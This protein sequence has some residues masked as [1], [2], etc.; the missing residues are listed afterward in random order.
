MADKTLFG[1]LQ[2]LFS[3][4][5]IVRKTEKGVKIV[6]TDEY[7]NMTTNLVDRYMKLKVSNYGVGG[8]ESAMA[9]QQVRIDLFR[10]YDSMDMDP[11][12][13]SALD[14][15]ADEC[16]AKNEHGSILKIHHDDDNIKQ[17]LENLFYDILNIE[18]NLW[19]WTRNLVKY[20]DFFLEL[21]I[22]DELGIINVMPLSS[23]EMSRVEGFDPENPQR[24]KFVY[25]PYQNPYM[26]VGQTT[27]KEFENYEIA[28]FRLNSDSNF[29]PYGKSMVEGARRVWKQLMLMEDAMLIHRVM[30]APEKRIFKVDVGNIPPNEVDNYMQ[31]IINASKK[32]PFVD[33]RTGEYNLKYNMM[34]LIE[35]YYMPVRG[36][37]N[38]TSIDT[39]KG[40]EYNM[41][42]DINYLKGKL[43]AALKIPKA[44][45]GYEE[46]TNGKATLA[47]MDI[48][49]AKTIERVQRVLISELTKIA[50][51]HLYAQG[52]N[53]DRLTDFTLELTVP[54]R[55]YEQEQVELYTSK[56]A[57]IQQMQQTKMFS[58]EWMYESVM[59][60]AKD[61]QDE[62]TLQ[63]LDDT[64][65]MFRL[66]SI[67]TQGV[68]PAKETGTEGGPTN[69]EEE[70]NK[71]KLE[72]DGQVG[73]PKDPVRYGHD[74][75]PEG[76]DP[77][78]IKTLKAKEGSVPY[79]P[80]KSSYFEVFKD[81]DGNKKTIL[82]EDLT[83][84]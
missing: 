31:K 7:Q 21:E 83:K 13:S 68:D 65:Q 55:I 35:D 22:A 6:D 23:Y 51:V 77:L 11:I 8:V 44:Y 63:V 81:M 73:R 5:T 49:F 78:G 20:G 75:H 56:V 1:R 40:L 53:D 28:H 41:I 42:D 66:T 26:A 25:A 76:R 74:D 18:F 57:L 84:K 30:R 61:E 39:L 43:M 34:N 60:M 58:K 59:K 62:L 70:L 47:S 19:P 37:D 69:V 71:L 29:L 27:K 80:R 10:D 79:K 16:T 46:D 17:I 24:V 36:S 54:S 3:T 32:V 52:I 50:I 72:L 82:T 48:R 14:V 45:L 4:N 67:E 64:K 33:E 9:Y 12:L 2:K 15:Y 38:G